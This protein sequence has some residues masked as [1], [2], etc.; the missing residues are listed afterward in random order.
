MPEI[1]YFKCFV[2][3]FFYNEKFKC[4]DTDKCCRAGLQ[5]LGKKLLSQKPFPRC[6]GAVGDNLLGYVWAAVCSPR[7]HAGDAEVP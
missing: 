3:V 4:F 5:A 2:F 6:R 7:L 1:N